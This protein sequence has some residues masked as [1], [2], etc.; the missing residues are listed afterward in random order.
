[1][2]NRS[3]A[4]NPSSEKKKSV[5]NLGGGSFTAGFLVVTVPPVV[6]RLE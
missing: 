2:P 1:M 4:N 3:K 6:L 5:D